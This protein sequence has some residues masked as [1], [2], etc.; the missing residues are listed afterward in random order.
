MMEFEPSLENKLETSLV[1]CHLWKVFDA[2]A[3]IE[4]ATNGDISRNFPIYSYREIL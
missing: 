1:T 4:P 3:Q 2:E